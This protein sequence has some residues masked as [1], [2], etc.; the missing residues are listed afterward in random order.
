V[1]AALGDLGDAPPELGP[2]PG[3][4]GQTGGHLVV[5]VFLG[6]LLDDG[7]LGLLGLDNI[8]AI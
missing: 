6:G 7:I 3:L 5:L 4:A 1:L 2:A 8:S